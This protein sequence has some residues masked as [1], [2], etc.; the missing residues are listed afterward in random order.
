M[1][2]VESVLEMQEGYVLDFSDRTFA[3]FFDD[4]GVNIGHARFCV[5]GMSKAK[6]LRRF[7]RTAEPALAGR[8]LEALLEHRLA[9]SADTLSADELARFKALIARLCG[10]SLSQPSQ[11]ALDGREAILGLRFDP[12]LFERLPLE[13]HVVRVLVERMKEAQACVRVGAHL[14]AVV[15]SGSVLEGLCLGFG[16][17]DPETVT[18]AYR[19]CLQRR[20]SEL[21]RW[22]LADWIRTLRHLGW[23]SPNIEKF[24]GAL[25]EFRNY[26][27]PHHQIEARFV[28][29][30]NTALI[31]F[32]VVVAA[33]EELSRSAAIGGGSNG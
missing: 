24:G 29:D 4:L 1:R 31:A 10:P 8:A 14:A 7:L 22:G 16:R 11:P 21:E 27:H 33:A 20:P 17:R 6:R 3:E 9:T 26:V 15:L 18:Q 13:P 19:E 12:D 32:Q 25:R 5:D 28:P 23:I 2:L 30:H